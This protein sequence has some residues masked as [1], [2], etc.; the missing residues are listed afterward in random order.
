MILLKHYIII[1][2]I[3]YPIN[4]QAT[5]QVFPRGIKQSFQFSAEPH[6]AEQNGCCTSCKISNMREA[7]TQVRSSVIKLAYYQS[8][9]LGYLSVGMTTSVKQSK[10]QY[11]S[12]LML[13]ACSKET[14]ATSHFTA[15]KGQKS[16]LHKGVVQQNLT[17]NILNSWCDWCVI[18]ECLSAL[19][20][21]LDIDEVQ[22]Q[23]VW[24]S[25]LSFTYVCI[26]V[27]HMHESGNIP[28][29]E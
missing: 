14:T 28:F 12:W 19:S 22:R 21:A 4:L 11:S 15:S 13:T 3:F 8:F 24:L 29:L 23:L 9:H 5:Y 20:G 1:W 7:M 27:F 25:K 6:V 18:W 10:V 16:Q 17:L 2:N 26:S